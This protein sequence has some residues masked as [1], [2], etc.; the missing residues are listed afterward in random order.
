MEVG[1][2]IGDKAYIMQYIA[3]RYIVGFNRYL[4]LPLDLTEA[5]V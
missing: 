4:I 2:I 3:E 5:L 1:T